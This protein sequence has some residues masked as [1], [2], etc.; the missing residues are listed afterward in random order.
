M[1]SPLTIASYLVVLSIGA[2]IIKNHPGDV[3][4]EGTAVNRTP[5][6]VAKST[7]FARLLRLVVQL[8]RGTGLLV[9]FVLAMALLFAEPT[10]G[11]PQINAAAAGFV[12]V[13]TSLTYSLAVESTYRRVV[14]FGGDV[15]Q[16]VL[17]E[18]SVEANPL[19]TTYVAL[20]E[21]VV[22]SLVL[23]GGYNWVARVLSLPSVNELGPNSVAALLLLVFATS[24][25]YSSIE[26]GRHSL[27]T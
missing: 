12:A 1:Y 10:T 4:S 24:L 26:A 6:W 7:T 11:I 13:W 9:G 21:L 17:A 2:A 16:A 5:L 15:R 18:E 8:I 20:S 14:R 23:V 25:V 19:S 27:N 22:S 3:A